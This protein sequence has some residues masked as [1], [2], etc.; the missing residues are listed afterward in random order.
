MSPPDWRPAWQPDRS[1]VP[2]ACARVLSGTTSRYFLGGFVP[3]LFVRRVELSN[4]QKVRRE[5]DGTYRLQTMFYERLWSVDELLRAAGMLGGTIWAFNGG[6]ALFLDLCLDIFP[7]I[8]DAPYGDVP[9]PDGSESAIGCHS[10]LVTAISSDRVGFRHAW[11]GWRGHGAEDSLVQGGTFPLEYVERYFREAW[12]I[13]LTPGPAPDSVATVDTGQLDS[14]ATP[15]RSED[16]NDKRWTPLGRSPELDMIGCWM[17]G[18]GSGQPWLQCLAI[19]RSPAGNSTIIG[20]LHGRIHGSAV[21][22]EELFVWA[23]DR[24][25]KIGAALAG[26]ALYWA[27]SRGCRQARWL[28][29]ESDA[30]ERSYSARGLPNW[31][32][33]N[34]LA[35]IRP[36]WCSI[37]YGPN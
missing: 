26:G 14:S 23:P 24:G 1:S 34:E 11:Q 17:E 18:V 9:M 25:R 28:E 27:S 37:R 10:V 21:D 5:S 3:P 33:A 8:Y 15:G 36:S 16:M 13:R 22:I 31:L 30:V 2:P 12:A 20:W 19:A 35:R 7:R 4:F 6:V 32:Q 29:L